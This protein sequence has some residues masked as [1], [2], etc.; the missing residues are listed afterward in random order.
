LRTLKKYPLTETT[1]LFNSQ[2]P[3]KTK[4][5][6]ERGGFFLSK[7]FCGSPSGNKSVSHQ[8][9]GRKP[10]GT[11]DE[12]ENCFAWVDMNSFICETK[13]S[14]DGDGEGLNSILTK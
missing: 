8:E 12:P 6:S 14:R 11:E 3:P 13:F 2:Y 10:D 5:H 4:D 1:I 7:K 9:D